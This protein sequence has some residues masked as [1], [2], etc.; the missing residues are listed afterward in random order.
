MTR[1]TGRF[2][3]RRAVAA[4]CR[5][6]SKIRH[7]HQLVGPDP[8]VVEGGRPA[9]R[10]GATE[11][12][13]RSLLGHRPEVLLAAPGRVVRVGRHVER[14]LQAGPDAPLERVL[15]DVVAAPEQVVGER[16]PSRLGR[17]DG[18]S[19]RRRCGS[20][21]RLESLSRMVSVPGS[22]LGPERPRGTGP[23]P[24]IESMASGRR[25]RRTRRRSARRSPRSGDAPR[26]AWIGC[27]IGRCAWVGKLRAPRVPLALDT[28][29]RRSR[30]PGSPWHRP[31]PCATIGGPWR[32]SSVVEQ[33]THKPLVGGSNPP[34]A[35]NL[36]P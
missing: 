30:I 23:A 12:A 35:T 16:L 1:P 20:R 3:S 27:W 32:S 19:T 33:G 15:G 24:R 11:R 22:A 36:E 14:H 9:D 17:R 4:T 26:G 25:L 31:G 18:R 7:R 10:V 28:R 13:E 29:R 8:E 21:R 34:S 5:A 6:V 2:V